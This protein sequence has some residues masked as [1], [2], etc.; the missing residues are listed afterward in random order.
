[1]VFIGKSY[2]RKSYHHL[3][4]SVFTQTDTWL[5]D[6]ERSVNIWICLFECS[7]QMLSFAKR[8]SF[9]LWHSQQTAEILSRVSVDPNFVVFQCVMPY[10]TIANCD[11]IMIVNYKQLND[12]IAVK[13]R[14]KRL[15]RGIKNCLI[16]FMKEIS[17]AVRFIRWSSSQCSFYGWNVSNIYLMFLQPEK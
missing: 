8:A 10:Y 3:R 16:W 2:G 11:R 12:E 15:L 5:L 7:Y 4:I 1:M 17:C 14:Q 6:Y 13:S 9:H